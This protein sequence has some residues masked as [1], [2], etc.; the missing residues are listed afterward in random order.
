MNKGYFAYIW[1]YTIYPHLEPEFLKAYQPNGE[2]AC[3]F[4]RDPNY[5]RTELQQSSDSE[6]QYMTID[7]WT[8]ES[9][10]D[11]FRAKYCNEFDELD[12]KCESYTKSE[13]LV[14]DFLTIEASSS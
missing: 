1:Q 13:V 11:A 3:L 12:Q 6:D 9:A 5:I 8:S 10:R 4:G 2:W 7:Y 14:G